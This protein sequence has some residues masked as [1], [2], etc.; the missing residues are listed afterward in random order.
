[1]SPVTWGYKLK[2]I[3][4]TDSEHANG[5]KARRIQHFK[6]WRIEELKEESTVEIAVSY[7][8]VYNESIIDLINPESGQL[9]I[10]DDGKSANIAG[11]S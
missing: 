5:P 1:M 6:D 7:L 3:D 8:E 11:S 10:R 2:Y 4:S 9:A